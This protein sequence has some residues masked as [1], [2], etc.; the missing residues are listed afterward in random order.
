MANLN[1]LNPYLTNN[2]SL[3]QNLPNNISNQPIQMNPLNPQMNLF[4]PQMNPQMNPLNPPFNPQMNPL[5]PQMNPLNPQMIPFNPQFNPIDSR[6]TTTETLKCPKSNI[7]SMIKDYN[8]HMQIQ[9]SYPNTEILPFGNQLRIT[10]PTESLPKIKEDIQLLIKKLDYD[11]DARWAYLENDG[12]YRLYEPSISGTIESYYRK[13]LPELIDQDYSNY[14]KGASF[15]SGGAN[16]EVQF[17]Q[18]GG[19]H[20]QIRKQASDTIRAVKRQANG[21]EINK[22]FIKNYRWLWRHEDGKFRTYEDD[23][24]FLIE[25]SYINWKKNPSTSITLIQGSNTMTYKID[26][27]NMT[28]HNE[29]TNFQRDIQR[30]SIP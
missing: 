3:S 24:I 13:Y 29:K 1:N 30:E 25:Q 21:E 20:R 8:L 5:N 4:N 10:A 27:T 28:Q 12:S 11:P 18:I 17:A 2:S 9:T 6:N 23:A 16:Y 26:F 14:S 7:V 22:G 19:V 15:S